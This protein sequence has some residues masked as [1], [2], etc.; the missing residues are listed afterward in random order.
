MRITYLTH[1]EVNTAFAK[2]YAAKHKLRLTPTAVKDFIGTVGSDFLILDL[3]HLPSECKADLLRE[4][5]E[6]MV[7]PAIAV[8]SYHL[9][10]EEIAVLESA[11]LVVSKRVTRAIRA[12]KATVRVAF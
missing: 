6:G 10:D 5:E 3:D 12:A 7:S 2:R 4:A 8:H 11:G 1:D 9:S